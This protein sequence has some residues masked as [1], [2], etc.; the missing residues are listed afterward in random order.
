MANRPHTRAL[1]GVCLTCFLINCQPS[2]PYLTK[3]LREDKGLTEEQLDIWVWPT[4]TY[5]LLMILLPF[6]LLAEI[7]GEYWVVVLGLLCRQAT[8]VLLLYGR[9]LGA[10]MIMQVTYAGAN[11]ANTVLYALVFKSIVSS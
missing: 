6:G 8:R 10:M 1:V 2:E 9:G 5:A 4:D 7:V 11:A 3:Y